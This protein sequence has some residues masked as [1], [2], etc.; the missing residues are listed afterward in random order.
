[1]AER[2][3]LLEKC[4]EEP[5]W[6]C[7]TRRP[8]RVQDTEKK[9]CGKGEAR[10]KEESNMND[11]F[12]IAKF[13]DE[14]VRGLVHMASDL[15]KTENGFELTVSLPAGTEKEDLDIE[16]EDN[17]VTI[18]YESSKEDGKDDDGYIWHERVYNKMRR[19]FRIPGN[20]SAETAKAKLENGVLVVTLEEEKPTEPK[21]KVAID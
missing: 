6:I 3:A 17:I 12:G 16:I 11:S 5:R 18:T 14:P 10:N 21:N 1:M 9:Q 13:F 2:Y 19:D 7:E 15:Q 20:V 4:L 8:V